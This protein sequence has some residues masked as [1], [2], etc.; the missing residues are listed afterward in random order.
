M[1]LL[2]LEQIKE[3]QEMQL[4]LDTR[5]RKQHNIDEEVDLTLEKYI[6]LKTELFEFV[7]EIESFKY[8]KVNKGKSH[9]LEEASDTLH[10]ILSLMNDGD[11]EVINEMVAPDGY[12][13]DDY[14]MN[15]L[16]GIV[17]AMISDVYIEKQWEELAGVLFFLQVILDKCGY[18]GED[19][20]NAYKSK[21]EVN[22]ARQDNNY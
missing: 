10:F 4:G 13:K 7:N 14:N 8:W 15:E 20:Y 19:L 21:N 5:I 11:V 2:T 16:I 18:S 12:N 9:I 6:A 17:D 22:H 1:K 3:M